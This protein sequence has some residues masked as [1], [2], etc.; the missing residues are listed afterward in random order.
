MICKG[1]ESKEQIEALMESVSPYVDG[2]YVTYTW[3]KGE[4]TEVFE[5][6]GAKLSF[7]KWIKQFDAARNFAMQ[8]IPEGYEYMLWL[9]TDDILIGGENLKQVIESGFDAYYATYNY[10]IDPTTGEVLQKH[11][12]ERL[13]KLGKFDWKA[14]LHETLIP[15]CQVKNVFTD[16]FVVNHY[17]DKDALEEGITRNIDILE[18]AYRDE[19]AAGAIDPRTEYYLARCYY[20]AGKYAYAKELL[21]AYLKHSGW[22]E[23]RAMANN[24]LAEISR[25]DGKLENAVFYL[26]RAISERPEFPSWYISLAV[27]Y[28]EKGDYDKALFHVK[29]GLALDQPDTAMVLTP[30]DD[31]LRALEVVF[32]CS[33]KKNLLDEALAAAK[34]VLDLF[35]N[36]ENFKD[37]VEYV[38]YLQKNVQI[39]KSLLELVKRLSKSNPDKIEGLLNM[40]PEDLQSTALVEKL[41][42]KHAP[43]KSHV[44]SIVYF[45]GKGFEKWDETSLLKGIGGSE[46]AVIQLT[47]E[48]A[49]QGKEVIVY[50]D[51]E[52]EHE[53]DGVQWKPY[54]RFN[55]HDHYDTLIIWR[56]ESLL[57]AN[58]HAN[59]IFFDAHDVLN[60]SEWTKERI[61]KVDKVFV[62]SPYHRTFIPDVPD[63]KIVIVPNG[64]DVTDLPN[65]EKE[66]YRVVYS[67]SYDRGLEYGLKYGWPIIKKAIPEAEL[68]IYYGWNLFD[69]FYS[70]NPERM[71]WKRSMQEL[72]KQPGV[73]EH[74]RVPQKEL[75]KEKA[76]SAVHYYPCTFEEIDCIGVRESAAV[77]CVPF[78]TA[79][80]AL[81]GRAYCV[82][83]PGDPLD[84]ETHELLADAIVTYLKGSERYDFA[85]D[86]QKESWEN[87]AKQW[88]TLI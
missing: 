64:I 4:A 80:A 32:A 73:T 70:N 13:V 79:Y 65:E 50:G 26:L 86:A 41:R 11:P 49:K 72:M 61:A 82:N 15:N 2:I 83:T 6:Y 47:K 59:R 27:V 46:T 42:Q 16:A 39:G 30:R 87:I 43:I 29:Q 57:S 33:M 12:R 63:K 51:P 5:K 10:Q 35:P 56:N 20:D 84:K 55:A 71:A 45:C 36:D 53:A 54:W 18:Q 21:E 25:R 69:S 76:R 24:Y 77:G 52:E 14:K 34:K 1:T 37:R 75:L 31:K 23:E 44:N 68:H 81:K 19:K 78:T 48:W 17:P 60:P 3:E 22:D 40:L 74:G 38:E 8:Q 67:S 88:Y 28:A 66:P 62:K 7:F 85:E 9:D 58:L